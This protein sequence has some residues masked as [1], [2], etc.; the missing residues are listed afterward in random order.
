MTSL[1]KIL[2]KRYNI[3]SAA[4]GKRVMTDK[5]YCWSKE[6]AEKIFKKNL[7]HIKN[8]IKRKIDLYKPL[9]IETTYPEFLQWIQQEEF[10]VIREIPTGCKVKIFLI[11]KI[12]AGFKVKPLINNLIK[13]F[14]IERAYYALAEEHIKQRIMK[15]FGISDTNDIRTLEIADFV[16][17]ALEKDGLANLKKFEERTKFKYFLGTVVTYLLFDFLREHYQTKKNLTKFSP[18][19]EEL[20]DQPVDSPYNLITKLEDEELKKKAAAILPKILEKLVPVEKMVIKW[21]YED[22]LTIS[23]TARALGNTRFKTEK[24]IKETEE[25]IRMEI[26]LRIKNKGGQNGT[27]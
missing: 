8:T 16:M 27:P 19:F 4:R 25:K 14:L 15:K 7:R 26:L 21:K 9:K 11:R 10:K 24:L 1:D 2:E 23:A 17:K 12:I 5:A 22:N 3:I 18:E 13:N 6:K 20:F